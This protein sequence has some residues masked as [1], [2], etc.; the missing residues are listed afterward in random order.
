[1]RISLGVAGLRG[2]C[3]EP[4]T[5]GGSAATIAAMHRPR[6]LGR[7]TTWL[8]ATA[9]TAVLALAAHAAWRIGQAA[10]L[11]RASQ[12]LQ[13]SPAQAR[14]RLLIVGDST[15]VGTGASSARN[16]LAGLIGQ[17]YPALAIEN[18]AQDGA[19]FA[20]VAAQLGG[21]GHFDLVLVQAGGNDVIRGVGDDRLQADIERVVT[22]AGLAADRVVLMPAGNVG[23]APFFFAPVSWWMTRRSRRLHALV[24]AAAARHAALYVNLFR[25]RADDPFAHQRALHAVD[26]LH[27]SDAG[28]RLWFTALTAQ[29]DLPRHLAAAR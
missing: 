19:R 16:S 13:Q 4:Q 5:D 8:L 25:E 27:P 11:A 26:G 6:R 18:R 2:L 24:R 20:D 21:A 15:A 12:A 17:A 28:Y 7:P 1:M 23:N 22:L 29:A 3:A 14:L 9:A 10:A